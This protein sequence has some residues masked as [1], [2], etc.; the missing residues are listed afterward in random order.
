[1]SQFPC[2][3]QFR[4][5]C[6][7]AASPA[8]RLPAVRWADINHKMSTIIVINNNLWKILQFEI[9][10]FV[11][12]RGLHRIISNTEKRLISGIDNSIISNCVVESALFHTRIIVEIFLEL[13]NK[14]QNPDVIFLSDLLKNWQ[15]EKGLV[16]IVNELRIAYGKSN[17][18]N[19]PHWVLNKILAHPSALRTTQYNY[20]QVRKALDPIIEEIIQKINEISGGMIT[21][22][23]I[24]STKR[25][26]R[27]YDTY[28]H[29][30]SSTF[31][32][33]LIKKE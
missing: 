3:F 23:N 22:D 7:L 14:K 31:I 5:K 17:C 8:G 1:V 6:W 13:G 24:T 2:A 32:H 33:R 21:G 20:A 15:T 16:S 29:V 30:V 18:K 4:I 25:K 19:T 9:D 11:G 10:M 28:T 26:S 12:A 27:E